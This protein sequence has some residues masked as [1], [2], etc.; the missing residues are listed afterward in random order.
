[1]SVSISD[2]KTL[3][4]KYLPAKCVDNIFEFIVNNNV[5]F[6]IVN[7][8]ISKLGDYLFIPPNRHRI[9]INNNLNL[10]Q[11]LFV[12]LHEFA[13]LKTFENNKRK[14][15]LPHGNEWKTEFRNLLLPCLSKNIFPDDLNVLLWKFIENPQATSSAN[16]QLL[17]CFQKYNTTSETINPIRVEDIP[18]NGFFRLNNRVFKKIRKRRTRFVCELVSTKRIYLVHGLAEVESIME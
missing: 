4:A 6:K 5:Q 1:M 8:R 17:K 11:F 14:R 7:K 2:N 9:T 16:I 12:T 18:L 3:L 13:H 10:Y 15:L